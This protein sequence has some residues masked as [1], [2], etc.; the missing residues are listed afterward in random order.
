[1][2]HSNHNRE[3]ERRVC[4]FF[5]TTFDT[6]YHPNHTK[7]VGGTPIYY[8]AGKGDLEG[9]KLLLDRGAHIHATT[10]VCVQVWVRICGCGC[11]ISLSKALTERVFIAFLKKQNTNITFFKKNGM[12]YRKDIHRF[13]LQ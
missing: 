5:P 7:K 3:R 6:I 9:M 10:E 13:T 12:K 4:F 2:K 11:S 8:A 1:M